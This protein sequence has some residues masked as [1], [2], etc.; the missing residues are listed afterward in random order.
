MKKSDIYIGPLFK[1]C[2]IERYLKDGNLTLVK[3]PKVGQCC[4]IPNIDEL[5]SNAVFIRI[6]SGYICLNYINK[7]TERL[8]INMGIDI[9]VIE[10]TPFETDDLFV[11]EERLKPYF[12]K[13]IDED[14][15]IKKLKKQVDRDLIAR[16]YVHY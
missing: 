1:C 7:F 15:N 4:F 3:E 11:I 16:N 6:A 10:K 14:I 13:N 9:N 8:L 5:I 2:N 12:K